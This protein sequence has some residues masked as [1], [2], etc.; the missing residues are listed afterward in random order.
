MP[1]AKGGAADAKE[2]KR[3]PVAMLRYVAPHEEEAG[4][5]HRGDRQRKLKGVM[6]TVRMLVVV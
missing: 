4:D 3:A 2:R 5:G 1:E 6:V